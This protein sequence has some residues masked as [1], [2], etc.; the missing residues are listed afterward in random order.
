MR[1]TRHETDEIQNTLANRSFIIVPIGL[2]TLSGLAVI[3][4][5]IQEMSVFRF[6]GDE[7]LLCREATG[8]R[9][10]V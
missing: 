10:M 4:S 9:R 6:S 7:S 1:Q 3:I 5:L 8:P 2:T